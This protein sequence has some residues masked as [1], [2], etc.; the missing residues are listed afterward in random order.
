MLKVEGSS[1]SGSGSISLTYGTSLKIPQSTQ[2]FQFTHMLTNSATVTA[3]CY[4]C[5]SATEIPYSAL[6]NRSLATLVVGLTVAIQMLSLQQ[7][8][9]TSENAHV[10]N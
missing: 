3:F 8:T 7:C 5:H 1:G 6:G 4:C 10:G 2:A 9:M